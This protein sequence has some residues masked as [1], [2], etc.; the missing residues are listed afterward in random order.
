[1]RRCVLASHQLE[2]LPTRSS[3]EVKD[4]KGQN[5]LKGQSSLRWQPS[6]IL[7]HTTVKTNKL[8]RSA[9]VLAPD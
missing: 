1:M 8:L 9:F 5:Y 4:L 2:T 6:S 7:H 3:L